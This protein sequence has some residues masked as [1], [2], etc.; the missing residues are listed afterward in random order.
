MAANQ[1]RLTNLHHPST[2][3]DEPMTFL[4]RINDNRRMASSAEL[5][6]SSSELVGQFEYDDA[7]ALARLAL[8]PH[9][10]KMGK[11]HTK[12]EPIELKDYSGWYVQ[13]TLPNGVENHISYFK[14]E[15]TWIGENSAAWRNSAFEALEASR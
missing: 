8:N 12:F 6:L 14:T 15:R 3:N 10:H 1:K 4:A 13:I 2:V 9:I 5:T 7:F 11:P